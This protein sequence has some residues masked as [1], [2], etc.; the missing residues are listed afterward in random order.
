[1]RCLFAEF[2]RQLLY[3]PAKLAKQFEKVLSVFH[4]V[5]GEKGSE[6][7]RV[8]A[9]GGIKPLSLFLYR[10]AAFAFFIERF[11]GN[12]ADIIENKLLHGISSLWT[13]FR[14]DPKA[15]RMLT[16]WLAWL[17]CEVWQKV[18]INLTETLMI[19]DG[20]VGKVFC[21]TG[22]LEVVPYERN[23]P[24]IILAKEI[25]SEVDK[26]VKSVPSTIPMFVDEWAFQIATNWCFE[27]GPNCRECPLCNTCLV[28]QGSLEH[29]RWS[30]YQ[31]FPF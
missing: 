26:V 20:H 5:G 14:D 22:A 30:A 4:Q 18:E 19:V 9:L 13:F 10:F 31:K 2:G 29:L 16:N 23:R 11:S 17:F 27:S 6:I 28:G 24:F 12:L 21:R 1:A 8:G 25:R 7:Y 15:A 3:E